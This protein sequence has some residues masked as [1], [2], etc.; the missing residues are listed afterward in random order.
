MKLNNYQFSYTVFGC[1]DE[2]DAQ[3]AALLLQARAFTDVSYAPYSKFRVACVAM[4]SG[5][6]TVQG[7]NQENAS[8]PVGICAERSLLATVGT[9]FPNQKIETIAIAY[10]AE[11][12]ES[13]R[14]IS[15]CGMCRQALLDYETRVQ[16]Q[17]R[18]LLGGM[19]GE[20]YLID[21]AAH[22]LPLAFTNGDMK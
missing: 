15:P 11:N 16:H 6:Q 22:L 4:L 21:S 9:M 7:T 5:G 1:I 18:I 13:S 19:K 14:P 10:C 8:F 17:M 3:D 2:L 12:G 20:I